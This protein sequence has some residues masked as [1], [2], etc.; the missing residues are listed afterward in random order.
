MAKRA[1]RGDIDN[2]RLSIA[3]LRYAFNKSTLHFR[4]LSLRN[5][6]KIIEGFYHR[7]ACIS[8]GVKCPDC[9]HSV[10]D[11]AA[12]VSHCA[13]EHSDVSDD[14]KIEELSF[15]DMN[16]F[17]LWKKA[18]EES[19]GTSFVTKSKK[20][21]G[22]GYNIYYRCHRSGSPPVNPPISTT[23]KRVVKYCTAFISAH[24]DPSA[25]HQTT[26]K[27]CVGHIGHKIE[28]AL[29][30]LENEM[31]KEVV[32]YVKEGL[33]PTQV[34]KKIREKFRNP[35][36]LQVISFRAIIS[37]NKLIPGR[38][39][40][41][42]IL[43]LEMRIASK[44]EGDGFLH[45][46]P[47]SNATGDGFCL[48][49]M[50]SLQEQW[51][52]DFAW[53]GIGIDDTFNIT[54]YHLR[55][56]TIIVANNCDKSLPAAFLLSFRMSQ[57]ELELLFLEIKK[58]I[59]TFAP[60]YFMS[61]D[62]SAFF[63]AYTKIFPG[64][65]TR[66][67]LCSWHVQRAIRKNA[68]K[69][70]IK[71]CT[72]LKDELMRRISATCNSPSLEEFSKRYGDTLTFLMSHGENEMVD[73]THAYWTPRIEEWSCHCRK[74]A[75]MHTSMLCERWHRRLKRE[76]FCSKTKI[77]VDELVD[78]LISAV[79][80]S[81]EESYVSEARNLV[82]GR[83]RLQ[84]Q[85]TNHAKALSYYCGFENAV[86][87][88]GPGRWTVACKQ[89]GKKYSVQQDL[90]PCT[91]MNNHCR[92]IG[93]G[94]C[95]YAFWC[96]CNADRK[97]GI[98]CLHVHAVMLFAAPEPPEPLAFESVET[99]DKPPPEPVSR[100]GSPAIVDESCTEN[101]ESLP[102]GSTILD[103]NREAFQMIEMKYSYIKSMLLQIMED[104]TTE[105]SKQLCTI[106]ADFESIEKKCEAAKD[107]L[108]LRSTKGPRIALRGSVKAKG[109]A[110]CD[111]KPIRL[112]T[113]FSTNRMKR[114]LKERNGQCNEP[115]R[116]ASSD[117]LVCGI[118]FRADPEDAVGETIAWIKCTKCNAWVHENYCAVVESKCRICGKGRLEYCEN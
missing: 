20:P 67:L 115:K 95:P 72:N 89:S 34:K 50:N 14:F 78:S 65:A 109:P 7:N 86:T 98:N 68:A 63:N 104:A 83:Y 51:M 76:I 28:Y 81:E 56:A 88:I 66:K 91:S 94:A 102:S 48:V 87:T 110:P 23:S 39:D 9:S 10:R 16:D 106:V 113:R 112:A 30:R 45:Y 59:P 58:K 11:I 99:T 38:Y 114:D 42:D 97:A 105:A 26:I 40:N 46:S 70:L 15:Q 27:F 108:G 100:I 1:E 55:L 111:A 41:N 3:L 12:L 13:E 43:S 92:K 24:F 61:D 47:A 60:R 31:E 96:E 74:G 53:R 107:H 33:T 5:N 85:H 8:N 93:C 62:A 4:V 71:V 37:R 36:A 118:C 6:R 18:A 29:L 44:N 90:C 64:S 49:I 82:G 79:K 17:Q 84:R 21:Y 57:A 32:H 54:L 22:N 116:Y 77:R 80:E 19:S 25:A 35:G 101:L 103:K 52:R 117:V 69:K 75:V 2:R 73:Y